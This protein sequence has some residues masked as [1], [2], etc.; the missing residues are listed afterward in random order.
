MRLYKIVSTFDIAFTCVVE[1][2]TQAQAQTK[3]DALV[4]F[5]SDNFIESNLFFDGSD[6]ELYIEGA[7]T[8]A[9][10]NSPP[11]ELKEPSEDVR[12]YFSLEE[13]PLP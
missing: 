10:E 5:D 9:E 6:G 13:E 2:E 11:E 8:V 1:A 4:D 12:G 7:P 3:Y